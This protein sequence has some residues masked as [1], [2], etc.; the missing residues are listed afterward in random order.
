MAVCWQNCFGLKKYE[1]NSIKKKKKSRWVYCGGNYV[2]E[3][4]RNAIQIKSRRVGII[5]FSFNYSWTNNDFNVFESAGGGAGYEASC[6]DFAIWRSYYQWIITLFCNAIN[7]IKASY[8]SW[9]WTDN[10]GKGCCLGAKIWQ[11][12]SSYL[13]CSQSRS[14][15][16]FTV[17]IR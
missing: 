9:H 4:I 3:V 17:I 13:L 6:H 12:F 10:M 2:V 8:G 14:A 11:R 5:S 1:A 7:I 16:I 15:D